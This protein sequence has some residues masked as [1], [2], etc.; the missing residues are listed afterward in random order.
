MEYEEAMDKV[1]YYSG[2][3]IILVIGMIIG[4]IIERLI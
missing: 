2:Y 4:F 1:N 3:L